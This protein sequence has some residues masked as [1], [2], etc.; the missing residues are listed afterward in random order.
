MAK[1]KT[2]HREEANQHILNIITPAGID[3]DKNFANVGENVGKIFA[4]TKY[5][6]DG[7]SYGW[8]ADLCNIEGT[9]TI[10]EYRTTEPSRLTSVF[11]KKINELK[12]DQELLKQESEKQQNEQAI[13]D[14]EEM[15]HRI[16]VRNEPVGY[17]NVMLHV[18]D[19]TISG[20]QNRIK[21][22]NSIVAISGCNMRNLKYKQFQALQCISPYGRPN[23]EVSNIG[24]RNMP[25]SSF[26]GGFPMSNPGINDEDGYY[27]GK[28][29]NNRLI[30]LNQWMRNKDRV[31]SN[32]FITGM[33]GVGKSSFLKSLFIREIAFGTKFIVFDPEKEYQDLARHP[34][35]EGDII[36]CAGGST[37]RINPLQIRVS[38]RVTKE[39]IGE[40]EDERDYFEYDEE[41]GVSDLALHIQNLR[42]FFKLYFGAD[43]FDSGIKTAL[44]ECLIEMYRKFGITWETDIGNLEPEDYPIL[45]DLYETV[46]EMAKR[47]GLSEYKRSV[48]DKLKDLLFS[49]AKGADQQMW[50]GPTTIQAKSKFVVLDMSKLLEVDENVKRAQFMN[51]TMWA[52]QQMSYDRTE[53]VLLGV[54]EGYLFVEPEYP[55]LGRFLRNISKRDRKYEAGLL[56]ITHSVV[57]LLDPAVKRLGQAIIDN[58]CYKFIMGCDGKNLEETKKLFNLSEKEENILAAKNRGQGILYAGSVR[59]D[60]QI[61]I[62]EEFME[63]FGKAGGR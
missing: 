51:I 60:A 18:Q 57:D 6:T 41:Y 12:S 35:V 59:I 3:Y 1:K 37:G 53:K 26:V 15:I 8:L 49:V 16:A 24:D 28:T 43:A 47:E 25:I 38:P 30:I 39:D 34:D 36:D 10:I 17:L 40:G 19:V 11:N 61:D 23:R 46:E 7:V 33:P 56:F 14:L 58:A 21:R 20:L 63:M 42:T 62:R 13:K 32:W 45:T 50:N 4:L 44:E 2:E 27:I 9:S 48:Y 52:W 5:P 54:D 22:V 29:K 55:D 31:N